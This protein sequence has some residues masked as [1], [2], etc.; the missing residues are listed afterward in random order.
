MGERWEKRFHAKTV[1][2]NIKADSQTKSVELGFLFK[3]LKIEEIY[4]IRIRILSYYN[5]LGSYE[6]RWKKLSTIGSEGGVNKKNGWTKKNLKFCLFII[7]L[8][9]MP[10]HCNGSKKTITYL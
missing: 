5:Y 7:R 4:L 9:N 2:K 8:A 3:L 6:C 10:V 1:W